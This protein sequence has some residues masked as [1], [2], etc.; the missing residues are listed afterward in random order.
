MQDVNFG[1]L[2]DKSGHSVVLSCH[3]LARACNRVF[4]IPFFDGAFSCSFSHSWL[5][6]EGDV[7]D[8]YPVG[9]LTQKRIIEPLLVQK[10]ISRW[11]YKA[12][13]KGRDV[14]DD[15]WRK[16]KSG[17]QDY[18]EYRGFKEDWFKEAVSITA[19]ELR[20]AKNQ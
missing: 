9:I 4:K 5:S 19:T 10:D 20:K 14:W 3:I 2:V 13:E 1:G 12:N 16:I 18:A 11:L 8:V 7:V 17:Q 15:Q 6:C